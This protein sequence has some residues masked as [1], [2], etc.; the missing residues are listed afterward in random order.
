MS[1]QAHIIGVV[2]SEMSI[3]T[4]IATDSVT[5]NSR[6]SRPTMP[7]MR[8]IGVNTAMSDMLIEK[9]VNPISRAPSSAASNGFMPAS[10]CRVM[11]SMTTIASST[12]KPVAI[13]MAMRD[14]LSM[15]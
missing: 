10:I 12:T 3:E 2:V 9:T 15:L 11:F 13:V 8:R 5:A 4:K 6:K 1:S 7:P 14:R